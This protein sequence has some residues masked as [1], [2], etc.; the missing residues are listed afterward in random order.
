[1]RIRRKLQ[2]LMTEQVGIVRTNEGL[3]Q[4]REQILE[5]RAEY[6]RLPKA[7]FAKYP[8]ESH[9]LLTS[10]LHVV[11]GAIARKHNVGLHFNRDLEA[12]SPHS[13]AAQP[14]PATPSA[15]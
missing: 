12:A 8:M 14:T 5:M 3:R 4:A 15:N 7:S 13:A 9:N 1:M 6:A 10:A 2:H 11:D